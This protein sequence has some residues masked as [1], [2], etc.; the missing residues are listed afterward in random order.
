MLSTHSLPPLHP[1]F[2]FSR[3]QVG[4]LGEQNRAVSMGQGRLVGLSIR[5]R[6]LEITIVVEASPI[7]SLCSSPRPAEAWNA[8]DPGTTASGHRVPFGGS[9]DSFCCIP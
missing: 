2:H 6:T 8:P 1:G 5:L 9:K 7:V 4:G 3:G